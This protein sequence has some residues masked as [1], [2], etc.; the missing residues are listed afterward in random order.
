MPKRAALR[1]STKTRQN[2][3]RRK[4]R[5]SLKRK[6]HRKPKV[7]LWCTL[8]YIRI[9]R[10]RSTI[11]VS[12]KAT[13]STSSTI[14]SCNLGLWSVTGRTEVRDSLRPITW[15]HS[16]RSKINRKIAFI[17]FSFLNFCKTNRWL[18]SKFNYELLNLLNFF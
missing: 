1:W 3:L 4:Q 10:N 9:H 18:I 6:K 17:P 14:P 16:K 7:F 12:K 13:C 11:S 5:Q 15:R 2:L 8:P